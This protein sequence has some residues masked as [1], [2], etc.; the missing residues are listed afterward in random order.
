MKKYLFLCV[1]VSVLS[2][3]GL[4]AMEDGDAPLTTP[5]VSTVSDAV[6]F[7]EQNQEAHPIALAPLLTDPLY[8]GSLMAVLGELSLPDGVRVLGADKGAYH[9]PELWLFLACRHGIKVEDVKD[10]KKLVLEE[11]SRQELAQKQLNNAADLGQGEFAGVDVTKRRLYMEGIV[12]RRTVGAEDAQKR[13]NGAAMH[14]L[15]F[16]EHVP[17]GERLAYLTGI[18]ARGGVGAEDAQK[19]LNGAAMHRLY[20]FE[21]VPLGERLAYLKAVVEQG[22]FG[23]AHAERLLNEYVPSWR[24]APVAVPASIPPAPVPDPRKVPAGRQ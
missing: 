5:K 18:V 7:A 1:C 10:R 8:R 22:T 20:F 11:L 17:L 6:S 12:A 14:R 23:A 24:N 9:N 16:F 15:Y 21:H 2:V 19:R 13:L 3:N 4:F